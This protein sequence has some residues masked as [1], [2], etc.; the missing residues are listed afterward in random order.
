MKKIVLCLLFAIPLISF[1]QEFRFFRPL[2][3][4][5]LS[6]GYSYS[7]PKN[8]FFIFPNSVSRNIEK[9]FDRIFDCD[10]RQRNYYGT[11][12]NRN[13]FEITIEPRFPRTD[14]H[15]EINREINREIIDRI[16]TNIRKSRGVRI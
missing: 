15:R 13:G 1:S 12:W 9:V 5:V 4:R 8:S 2:H 10:R 16:R 7:E 11:I 14:I 3:P 6:Y